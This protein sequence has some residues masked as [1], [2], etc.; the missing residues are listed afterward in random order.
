MGIDPASNMFRFGKYGW[1]RF[2]AGRDE[3][4]YG[5]G[6]RRPVTNKMAIKSNLTLLAAAKSPATA[7]SEVQIQ[8]LILHT[9]LTKHT[10][11]VKRVDG[12]WRRGRRG[13]EDR[14]WWQCRGVDS[15]GR[16]KTPELLRI[17]CA[18]AFILRDIKHDKV[19]GLRHNQPTCIT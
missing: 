16:R 9:T 6:R 3:R 5:R 7:G 2:W 14:R 8:P 11:V 1:P 19:R 18:S 10:T 13:R 12:P 4:D 17:C 15:C